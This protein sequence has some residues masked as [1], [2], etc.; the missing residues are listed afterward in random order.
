MT[1]T[2]WA[3][4]APASEV[5]LDGLARLER[6]AMAGFPEVLA[7]IESIVAEARPAFQQAERDHDGR[8][9]MLRVNAR[10]RETD[11]GRPVAGLLLSV[12]G[13]LIVLL[14]TVWLAMMVRG[15]WDVSDF[16]GWT[17]AM[18]LVAALLC[19]VSAVV[20]W[21]R[22]A[23]GAIG[24]GWAGGSAAVSVLAVIITAV[25]LEVDS[26]HGGQ[27]GPALQLAGGGAALVILVFAIVNLRRAASLRRRDGRRNGPDDDAAAAYLAF[28]S[29]YDAAVIQIEAATA[30]VQQGDRNDMKDDR[31]NAFALWKERGWF[32]G[33]VP[34]SIGQ[35]ALG[36][37]QL[38]AV[39][40][41]L[42]GRGRDYPMVA[43]PR[44][45]S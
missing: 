3:D 40:E 1:A 9:L 14:P 32:R 24:V 31:D 33:Q 16:L 4:R 11:R 20:S 12:A 27:F 18:G 8:A 13:F 6:Q 42:V 41:P 45:R 15:R 25:R 26:D 21:R 43:A 19:I 5:T 36:E 23:V 22:P 29:L 37:L 30:S 44:S 35:R 2:E 7:A 38:M 39:T 28:Q 17:T 10:L 34:A